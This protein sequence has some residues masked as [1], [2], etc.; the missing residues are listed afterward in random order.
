MVKSGT[1]YSR[2]VRWYFVVAAAVVLAVVLTAC[3]SPV[4]GGPV[5]DDNPGNGNGND[6]GNGNSFGVGA[7]IPESYWGRWI[8]LDQVENWYFGDEMIRRGSTVYYGSSAT[9]TGITLQA[10]NGEIVRVDPRTLRV[11]LGNGIFFLT[12]D[13]DSTV[14]FRGGVA[15]SVNALQA[16]SISSV[17]GISVVVRNVSNP[18]DTRTVTTDSEG[19]FVVEDAIAGSDYVVVPESIDIATQ[20]SPRNDDEDVGTVT[21]TGEQYQFK[22]TPVYPQG[23][24]YLFADGTTYA[25]Q[26]RVRN[27]GDVVSSSPIYTISGPPGMTI[28]GE[29]INNLQ[30]IAPGADRTIPVSFSVSSITDEWEDFIV[31]VELEDASGNVWNDSVSF[32]FYR[33]PLT[34]NFNVEQFGIRPSVIAP[35]GRVVYGGERLS[36]LRVPYQDSGYRVVF[37]GATMNT[38]TKYSIGVEVP[39]GDLTAV[40]NPNIHEPNNSEAQAFVIGMQESVISWLSFDDLDYFLIDASAPIVTSQMQGATWESMPILAWNEVAGANGYEVQ[41][42]AQQDFSTLHETA[43]LPVGTTS[44]E[45]TTPLS[46]EGNWYWRVRAQ[47]STGESSWN[48]RP[49]TYSGIKQIS[50]GREHTLVLQNDGTLWGFGRSNSFQTGRYIFPAV[51]EPIVV[52]TDVKMVS[53]GQFH[54]MFVRNNG[55]LWGVGSNSRGQLGRGNKNF[56]TTVEQVQNWTDVISVAAGP[57]HGVVLRQGGN[58]WTFGGNFYGQLGLG[59]TTEQLIPTQVSGLTNVVAVAAG[60]PNTLFLQQNGELYGAGLSSEIGDP[61]TPVQNRTTP[62]SVIEGVAAVATY[63]GVCSNC[64]SSLMIKNDGT[65]WAAGYNSARLLGLGESVFSVAPPQQVGTWTDVSHVSVGS[66]HTLVRRDDGSVWAAGSNDVGQFG[67]GTTTDSNVHVQ[68]LSNRDISDVYAG[69]GRSFFI[70]G[71]GSLWAVGINGEGQ[72]GVGDTSNRLVPTRVVP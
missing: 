26:I 47:V 5:G 62:Q 19:G 13:G 59:N 49:F 63:S 20:V 35:D 71:D 56:G 16:S 53:T 70:M 55:T 22:A 1:A 8:R 3:N 10:G 64:A 31:A 69:V 12:R 58:V 40:V 27:D 60:W 68:V 44:Y 17:A 50:A 57:G 39:A 67:N 66:T 23:H 43:S 72:L 61:V 32:R 36:T 9:E 15:A 2:S 24:P 11:D 4:Q 54:T 51:V 14:R 37:S 52:F 34:L 42:S 21:V 6:N 46:E 41:V 48:T 33:D 65:L 25:A 45:L 38:E 30:S 7:A 18:S 28:T 29:L